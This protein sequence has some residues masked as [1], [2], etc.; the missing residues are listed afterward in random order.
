M[1]ITLTQ[2]IQSFGMTPSVLL[3]KCQ[4]GEHPRY[5]HYYESD[6]LQ[7]ELNY[8]AYKYECN[9]S[10]KNKQKIL[11]KE[12]EILF[13]ELK[14]PQL[15]LARN[16]EGIMNTIPKDI[17]GKEFKDALRLF[18]L[19]GLERIVGLDTSIYDAKLSDDEINTLKEV[20]MDLD[21]N[22]KTGQNGK[23]KIIS[24]LSFVA[25]TNADKEH[26]INEIFDYLYKNTTNEE[27]RENIFAEKTIVDGDKLYEDFDKNPND[28]VILRVILLS[29]DTNN[30]KVSKFVNDILK[31]DN[32][33][34]DV[35]RIA[36]LGAGRFRS[37]ENFEI[38]KEIALN[39]DEKDIRK[40]EFAIH[41][42]ALYLKEK[43]EEVNEIMDTIKDDGTI[44]SPLARIIK[45]KINGNYHGQKDREIN[46]AKLTQKEHT[47][48]N[49]AMNN[50]F[51]PDEKLNLQ[52]TNICMRS[53]MPFLNYLSKMQKNEHTF[54]L[55]NDTITKFLSDD[56]GTRDFIPE[57]DLSYSGSF[58]DAIDGTNTET[59][60]IMN[61]KRVT[62]SNHANLIS[63]ELAHLLE[64]IDDKVSED[65]DQLYENAMKKDIVLNDYA[66]TCSSEYFA[67]G[68]DA[69]A[70]VYIPHSWLLNNGTDVHSKYELM[71]KDP[72]LYQY[73]DNLAK[74]S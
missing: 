14:Q 64:R 65:I 10:I 70:S 73:I 71:D 69:Y 51:I 25:N 50:L 60:S 3:D 34:K 7:G 24:V 36:V 18:S 32:R 29:E 33:S 28:D 8:L 61:M 9:F 57:V 58:N 41:S 27:I 31:S 5:E 38:I 37:D 68:F 6:K 43:P 20:Y 62:N 63:H 49:S 53:I 74:R 4:N 47:K 52:E 19:E 35:I 16:Y 67:V 2:Y 44:F 17:K 23:N 21:E 66:E 39:K 30:E 22:T 48:V 40:R 46:Y 1:N 55:T 12:Q 72:D 59:V 54:Y 15:T 11:K 26:K 13:Q 45:D 42:T 56:I